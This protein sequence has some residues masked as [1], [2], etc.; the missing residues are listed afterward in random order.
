[1][2]KVK[3]LLGKVAGNLMQ[4]ADMIHEAMG[5]CSSTHAR[6]SSTG[7]FERLSEGSA[8]EGSPSSD[9]SPGLDYVPAPQ[10]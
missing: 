7:T 2:S 3:E 6:N 9:G 1:M 10:R 8:K 4:S 5:Y